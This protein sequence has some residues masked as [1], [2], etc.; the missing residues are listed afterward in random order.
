MLY[1]YH[2]H[3]KLYIRNFIV[4]RICLLSQLFRHSH[5]IKL[6]LRQIVSSTKSNSKKI[7]HK[8]RTYLHQNL[9]SCSFRRKHAIVSIRSLLSTRYKAY[10]VVKPSTV[11]QSRDSNLYSRLDFIESSTKARRSIYMWL[12]WYLELC[13]FEPPV[14][15]CRCT[16]DSSKS[17]F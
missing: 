14:E 1:H 10:V 6:K 5:L 3:L 17:E 4:T 8:Y 16:I 15:H 12:E 2:F 9:A 13:E 11:I 7:C